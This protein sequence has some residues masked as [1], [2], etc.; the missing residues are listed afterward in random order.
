M[1]SPLVV[2]IVMDG[3]GMAP[4][5]AGNPIMAANLPNIRKFWAAYPHTTLLA[6]GEAVGLPRGEVGNTETGHLNLGAGR[7]VYQDL[8]RINMS[9][10]SGAYFRSSAFLEA[11][12]HVKKNNSR[13]HLMGLVGGGGV[14]SSSEHLLALL[15]LAKEQGLSQNVLVHAFTD[16]RDSPPT[17]GI[18]YITNIEQFMSAQQVGKFVSVMGRYWAMDRDLRWE[19]TKVAY[20]A[21]TAGVAQQTAS[22]KEAI[23]QSYDQGI[24]DEFIHP[25]TLFENGQTPYLVKENDA[26][27]FFNFRLDRPRQLAG[28][29]V[30]E[31][32]AAEAAKTR[33]EFD[34]YAE[35][36]FKKEN[37]KIEGSAIFK[38]AP[39]IKNLFFV[40][41]TEYSKV[42][43][44]YVKS[45]FPPEIVTL[46][47][48]EVIAQRNYLQLRLAESEK[49]R[50]VTYYF[51]GQ[52]ELAFPGETRTIARSP[53]VATYD[54]APKMSALEIF[55]NFQN[56][57]ISTS[58]FKFVLINFA[59]PDMVGHTGNY[60]AT[61]IAVETV[62]TCVG[63]IVSTVDSH[64]GVT[65]ITADH[66]NAEELLK[67]DG[68]IDTE[69]S[70]NPVPFIVVGK[71]FGGNSQQL[72]TGI[73]ADVAPTV[74]KLLGLPKPQEMTGRSLI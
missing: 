12:E 4:A 70:N 74:L 52:R 7:I 66:G 61:K 72:Q 27:I 16:G 50:F 34:P 23:Q 37:V 2:L 14:H 55:K 67:S 35:K 32:F 44:K 40:T 57:L 64:G 68:T 19:R 42:I 5:G 8:L 31:D 9:I 3:W 6:S 65:L 13:L 59:N 69:H 38:R 22:I 28:A 18:S 11:I 30:F 60:T 47:L 71:E 58:S 17:A 29:F 73:L 10:A 24:T 56:A 54:L 62:D 21:L 51:N 39:K 43:A 36:Y 45:A 53:Q 33:L 48:G 49:E 41:M 15:R 26:V 25:A 1:N 46:P 63:S 20:Q